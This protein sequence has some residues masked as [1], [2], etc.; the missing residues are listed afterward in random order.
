MLLL[1]AIAAVVAACGGNDGATPAATNVAA[2]TTVVPTGDVAAS[3]TTT[4]SAPPAVVTLP[5]GEGTVIGPTGAEVTS[6]DGLVQL[7]FPAGAVNKEV[8]VRVEA[9]ST[10]DWPDIL[11][12]LDP[13]AVV[14]RLEPSGL[15][16]AEPVTF[17]M[18]MDLE[19]ADDGSIEAPL[20]IVVDDQGNGEPA[21]LDVELDPRAGTAVVTG[22]LKHFS[23]VVG[24]SGA[25]AV[26]L[27]EISPRRRLIGEPWEATV[28][29]R[30]VSTATPSAGII[31][32]R[33][34]FE[35]LGKVE[36]VG[37]DSHPR[38]KL[39]AGQTKE[40]DFPV[41]RW[42]CTDVGEGAYRVV[43][44]ARI[45]G[46]VVS[47]FAAR[48]ARG[49]NTIKNSYLLGGLIDDV[50]TTFNALAQVPVTCVLP[51]FA[52]RT[53]SGKLSVS[54]RVADITAPF[55]LSGTFKG[56]HATLSFAPDRVDPLVNPETNEIF[57]SGSY[58]YSGGGSGTTV[59][60]DGSY[61][62]QGPVGKPLTLIYEGQGC[63]NPGGCQK[64]SSTITL[65]PVSH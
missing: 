10:E 65:T 14:Y 3:A 49:I 39:E 18:T 4:A 36:V 6:A 57:S 20:A 8:A 60:G 12:D 13:A 31:V 19:L 47:N 29:V 9:L 55:T 59:R 54:G 50:S 22:T 7:T 21:G 53:R 42:Q 23:F 30:N 61:Y 58:T 46:D 27:E 63:A 34:G 43:V 62:I 37:S 28:G 24:H 1:V 52:A 51:E 5:A 56:G 41:P 38:F 40:L 16:F 44:R 33:A 48:A 15:S 64:T 45:G 17:A 25:L 35:A 32:D 26:S 2:A 11:A